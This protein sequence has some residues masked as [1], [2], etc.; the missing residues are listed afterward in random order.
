LD[1]NTPITLAGA[2]HSDPRCAREDYAAIWESRPA[3]SSGHLAVAELARDTA[4]SSQ[5]IRHNCTAT[6]IAWSRALLAAALV[7]VVPPAGAGF[8]ASVR[9]VGGAGAVAG[10]LHRTISREERDR[11]AGLLERRG[12]GVVLLAVNRHPRDVEPLL[13]RAEETFAM[14]SAWNGLDR[15]IEQEIA[16]A[17]VNPSGT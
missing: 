3:E 5:V 17:Q 4:G 13:R 2:V 6:N 16:E 7:L 12:S 1:A 10:H 14:E 8:L 15:A 11:A 9:S